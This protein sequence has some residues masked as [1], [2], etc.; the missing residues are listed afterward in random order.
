MEFSSDFLTKYDS[1]AELRFLIDMIPELIVLK[2][3]EGRWLMCNR[4]VREIMQLDET[5]YK[6]RTDREIGERYPILRD[7]LEYNHMTDEQAW[8]KAATLVIEKSFEEYGGSEDIWEIIKTPTFDKQGN[9]ERMMSVSRNIMNRRI[10]EKKLYESQERFRFIAE[11]MTDIIT[12]FTMDRKID[13]LS[14]SLATVLGYDIELVMTQPRFTTL[15]PEDVPRFSSAFEAMFEGELMQAKVEC[16]YR[17]IQGH[18]IWFEMNMSRVSHDNGEEYVLVVGR[19]ISERKIHEQQLNSLAYMDPLTGV[20]NRRYLM[21]QLEQDIKTACQHNT[22]VGVLYLDVD[23][24]KQVNDT[25]GH[26]QGDQLLIQMVERITNE[27]GPVDTIARIGGDEFVVVLPIMTDRNQIAWMAENV[28]HTLQQPWQLG[29]ACMV[30]S[31]SIGISIYPNDSISTADLIR[32][33]DAAL[34]EAKRAGKAQFAF[35][36]DVFLNGR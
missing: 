28:C 1:E 17:H 14:P 15:H 21:K 34:Y 23:H 29:K 2:D 11:N 20:P 35:Y 26:E 24:F 4:S 18:Y 25:L 32:H 10:T 33:A 6:Y 12:I 19:D 27:L 9:R 31:S 5:Q 16:R 13:Y 22:M 7:I 36:E 30:T 8:N 3:G